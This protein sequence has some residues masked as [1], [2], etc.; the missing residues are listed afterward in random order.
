MSGESNI[1]AA[2][3]PELFQKIKAIQIRTQRLVTDVLAGEYE[4]AFKGRGMEFEEVR[5]YQPGDDIRTIDWNV[6]SRMGH[7][8]IKKYVEERELTVLLAVDCSASDRFGTTA[9][10]KGETAAE[11]AALIAFTA[12]KNNDRVGLLMFT[13]E[14]E[15]FVP[16]A[17]GVEHVLRVV[18]ELLIFKPRHKGT[19]LALGLDK[20]NHLVRKRAVVFLISDYLDSGYERQ[21]R[22]TARRHD[23]IAVTLDDPRE[24]ELPALGL[25]RLTDAES[26][27]EVVIDTSRRAV[28]RAFAEAAR[29]RH[30]ARAELL[31]RAGVDLV[32]IRTDRPYEQP[33]L[34]FFR[35]RER[36]FR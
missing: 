1:T 13:D 16:P 26:G 11:V 34:Q 36:R 15:L 7:P 33:L 29:R 18:R 23:L 25:L 20:V 12:I 35:R 21:L 19:D 30:E 10:T 9:Q 31:R 6:T 27:R 24:S 2:L 32:G 5:E 4:S 8:Y 28:R 22:L 3:P 14:V 17:K